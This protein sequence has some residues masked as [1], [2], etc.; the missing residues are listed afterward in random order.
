M[1][2]FDKIVK[3][4]TQSIGPVTVLRLRQHVQVEPKTLGREK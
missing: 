2:L 3:T 1:N 4:N